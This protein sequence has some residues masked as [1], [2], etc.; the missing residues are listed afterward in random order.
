MKLL[1]AV[2]SAALFLTACGD[3]DLASKNTAINV[4]I[5]QSTPVPPSGFGNEDE[6]K[7]K[8]NSKY[9]GKDH[10]RTAQLCKSRLGQASCEQYFNKAAC[11]APPEN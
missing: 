6:M 1:V 11:D 4:T 3:S 8:T 5:P 2:V 7:C 10:I 9:H